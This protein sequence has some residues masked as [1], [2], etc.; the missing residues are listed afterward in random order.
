ML[1][2]LC[3][4]PPSSLQDHVPGPS[5]LP[6]VPTRTPLRLP[7]SSAVRPPSAHGL[8][9]APCCQH[10]T[11][12][13]VLKSFL[14]DARPVRIT[15]FCIAVTRP[16]CLYN[17]FIPLYVKLLCVSFRAETKP[18]PPFCSSFW[19][20]PSGREQTVILDSWA[21]GSLQ[22]RAYICRCLSRPPVKVLFQ[23]VSWGR[24]PLLCMEPS[25]CQVLQWGLR[26]LTSCFKPFS[27]LL[28]C[29]FSTPH[30]TSLKCPDPG[31]RHLIKT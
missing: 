12:K 22:G 29:N 3:G 21:P 8:P 2:R 17:P 25:M 20:T 28:T 7:Y 13:S 14:L 23:K 15:L 1:L 4:P 27:T 6:G 30:C 16:H 10:P 31:N 5:A 19:F 9:C 11:L 24:L 18:C 26:P